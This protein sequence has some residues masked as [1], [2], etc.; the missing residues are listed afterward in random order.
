M[1]IGWA[2]NLKQ[3]IIYSSKKYI[4]PGN[5]GTMY[6]FSLH[7]QQKQSSHYTHYFRGK[8]NNTRKGSVLIL[9]Q[10]I[11][12]HVQMFSFFKFKRKHNAPLL[13]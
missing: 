9:N 1:Y 2:G 6:I 11:F 3:L 4:S 8:Q 12:V 13:S 7:S 5:S 10:T